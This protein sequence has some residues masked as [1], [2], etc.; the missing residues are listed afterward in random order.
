M[1]EY[2]HSA[3]IAALQ[4]ALEDGAVM[5]E[6][7][8]PVHNFLSPIKVHPALFRLLSFVSRSASMSYP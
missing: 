1:T 4:G 3:V 2:N 8:V 7:I 6:D 5:P